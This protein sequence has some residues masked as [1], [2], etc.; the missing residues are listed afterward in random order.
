MPDFTPPRERPWPASTYIGGE[1]PVGPPFTDNVET[2]TDTEY[3][4]RLSA[5]LQQ[6]GMAEGS[7]QAEAY[8]DA[9][10]P[11]LIVDETITL[12]WWGTLVWADPDAAQDAYLHVL[13]AEAASEPD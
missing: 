8:L 6:L 5:H 3:N 9:F 11:A 2:W 1:L 12:D 4:R 13:I 7:E 10:T